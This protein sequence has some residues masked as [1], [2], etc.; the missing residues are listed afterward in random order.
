MRSIIFTSALG[1]VLA[2]PVVADPI[3]MGC[4]ERTY[5]AAHIA[6][7]PNQIVDWVRLE[8]SENDTFDVIDA[9]LEARFSNQGRVK[10]TKSAGKI[11]DQLLSC[12]EFG[13]GPGCAV[14]CDG[15]SF[16]FVRVSE[17]SITIETEGVTLGVT[18]GCGGSESLAEHLGET[19]RYRLNRVDD[20]ICKEN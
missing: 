9:F 20:A 7:H 2:V 11:L 10:G 14:D 4:F 15:G 3:P 6:S 8:I 5:D 17:K 1:M 18:E 13:S 16:R 12:Q 19:V